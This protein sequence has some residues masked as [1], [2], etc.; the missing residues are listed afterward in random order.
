MVTFGLAV[1][2]IASLSG[3]VAAAPAPADDPPPTPSP[4]PSIASP[5]Q[6]ARAEAEW[7]ASAHSDT[8]DR[9]QGANTTCASC[10]SP[11]NWDPSSL[12]AETALD[13]YSCKR[14]PGAARPEL[15]G[16]QPV[17]EDMWQ[18]IQCNICHIPV[19]DSY[20]TGIAF[21]DQ[22][23]GTYQPIE[24][25]MELCAKCHEGQ[26]GFEV[27]EEQ[28]ASPI[29]TGWEC[30]KCHGAHGAPSAC[31]DCHDPS[32]VSGAAEHERHPDVDCTACHDAG[33]LTIMQDQDPNSVHVGEFIPVRFA[34][35]L[36]S[37]PSHDLT[38]DVKCV[39]CHHPTPTGGLA[40]DPTTACQKCHPDGA[41]WIWCENFTRDDDPYPLE[42]YP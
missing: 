25:V 32:Q 28:Q 40:V 38:T 16:G 12:G 26:H 11:M 6:L 24:S 42:G 29:H 33:G 18:D 7:L 5:E 8:Y 14:V 2:G 35:T 36:T 13:C 22:S 23:T 34:H 10:K 21:W 1:V 39:R 41:M 15:P 4:T 27:I 19:G 37:W 3:A 17:S 31:T 30:T 9:G 20:Q